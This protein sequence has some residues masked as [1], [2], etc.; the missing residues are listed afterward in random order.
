MP[1]QEPMLASKPPAK[2]VLP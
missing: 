1:V 2:P